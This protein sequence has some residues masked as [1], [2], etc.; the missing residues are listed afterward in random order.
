MR[1]KHYWIA[2]LISCLGAASPSFAVVQTLSSLPNPTLQTLVN[3]GS[4]PV[5]VG[6]L[7][8]SDFSIVNTLGAGGVT[9]DQIQVLPSNSG[10]GLQFVSSWFAANGS[11]VDEV[12]SF[13]VQAMDSTKPIS[14]ISLLS[15]GTAPAPTPGTFTTTTLVSE[16][17]SGATATG[18]ISTYDDGVTV[19]VDTTKPDVNYVQ[20]ALAPQPNLQISDT[21]F[22]SS[23]AASGSS[24]GGVAT[25]SIVQNT[26]AQAPVQVPEPTPMS[27]ILVPTAAVVS[28]LNRRGSVGRLRRSTVVL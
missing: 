25:E 2:V 28:Q 5:A 11:Y 9:A 4:T 23:T 7:E 24:T 3:M 1:A 10:T 6:G 13:D 15:N 18:L 14:Q 19:P 8:F 20:T 26:F 17:P 22:E 27:W 16:L 21:I 12:L